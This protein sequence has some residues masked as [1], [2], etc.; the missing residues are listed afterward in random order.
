MKDIIFIIFIIIISL[1]ILHY[2][3]DYNKKH[4]TVLES[5]TQEI[6]EGDQE[7]EEL[8]QHHIVDTPDEHEG[9]RAFNP[10]ITMLKDD[11][12]LS[13]RISNYIGCSM[14]SGKGMRSN[15]SSADMYDSFTILNVNSKDNIYITTPN[16]AH[17][18]C[19]KGF[20]DA[21]LIASPDQSKLHIVANERSNAGCFSEMYLLTISQEKIMKELETKSL[22]KSIDVN[23]ILRMYV[24]FEDPE[25][26]HHEKNWMP[27]YYNDD[28][29]FIYSVEPHVV[30][31]LDAKSG[32]CEEVA[33]TSNKNINSHLRGSSQ[34]R[35]YKGSYIAIAHWRTSTMSYLSQA[36]SFQAKPPFKIETMSPV[37]IFDDVKTKNK[38]S[39]Q[40]VSG[41][42]IK[43]DVCH[44]TYGE[45][46][47]D[48]KMFKVEMKTLLE[49]MK[50]IEIEIK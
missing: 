42:E 8:P 15:F 5:T 48:S 31:K 24:D 7:I 1:I 9:F 16:Y 41:M 10:S 12:I 11:L 4:E 49:S 37:F 28:L 33:R 39:I 44:I 18:G 25:P 2:V 26:I 29:H 47:C 40:F 35:Y 20:E 13:F 14:R 3:N 23:D 32:F 46:D 45:Q 34:A 19:V 30:L 17:K 6:F 22:T 36:Y 50:P 27:F 38:S 43:D 21:R